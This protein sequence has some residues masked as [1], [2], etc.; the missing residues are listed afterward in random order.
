M[1]G[2]RGALLAVV[3]QFGTLLLKNNY[4]EQ[5]SGKY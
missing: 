2:E 5:D 4:E 1:I 3:L